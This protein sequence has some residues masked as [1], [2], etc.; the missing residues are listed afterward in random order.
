MLKSS[1]VHKHETQKHRNLEGRWILDN[2][3]TS[4][5]RKE[6]Q[7]SY[8]K[9][10]AK[11]YTSVRTWKNPLLSSIKWNNKPVSDFKVQLRRVLIF[12]LLGETL[13]FVSAYW[14]SLSLQCSCPSRSSPLGQCESDCSVNAGHP[15]H[16]LP[17]NWCVLVSP[18]V[19]HRAWD[20][21]IQ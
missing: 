5:L 16:T 17:M 21:F 1:R 10:Q 7:S 8:Y 3:P 2:A 19:P 13:N 12:F 18:T 15:E 4:S 20:A 11:K 6:C 14:I 9:L